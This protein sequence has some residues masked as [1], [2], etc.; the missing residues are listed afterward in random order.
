[1][2][3][4]SAN[5]H[6]R[7]GVEAGSEGRDS[8][9]GGGWGGGSIGSVLKGFGKKVARAAQSGLHQIET[10]LENLDRQLPS[11]GNMSGSGGGGYWGST[12]SG[13]D[14]TGP[15]AHSPL[16]ASS[17][18][19]G[20][21]M[22]AVPHSREEGGGGVEV[23]STEDALAVAVRVSE[24]SLHEQE[25]ALMR[26]PRAMRMKVS[27]IM[28][29]QAHLELSA[30]LLAQPAPV[31]HHQR[32]AYPAT[33]VIQT[34]EFDI[35]GYEPAAGDEVGFPGGGWRRAEAEE[36]SQSSGVQQGDPGRG[37]RAEV[38]WQA[39][40]TPGGAADHHD[41]L[42]FEEFAPQT[43]TV[44]AMSAGP[45]MPAFTAATTVHQQAGAAPSSAPPVF[46]DMLDHDAEE[47][48]FS[49]FTAATAA[50]LP[51]ETAAAQHSQ[52]ATHIDD[53]DDFFAGGAVGPSRFPAV[54]PQPQLTQPPPFSSTCP[55]PVPSSASS[56]AGSGS[57]SSPLRGP[58]PSA[59][60]AAAGPSG[61]SGD[62][63][64]YRGAANQP[65]TARPVDNF[66]LG[67]L[68]ETEAEAHSELYAEKEVHDGAMGARAGIKG[69]G[70]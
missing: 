5:M 63:F 37:M 21:S 49:D 26:L 8:G 9:G 68:D 56:M 33:G 6:C 47:A 39:A 51:V 65:S 3:Y 16:H 57:S 4:A 25:G 11:L 46:P 50:H 52:A 45:Y 69:V 70:M 38:G 15:A 42:G 23:V 14:S 17:R 62:F 1:M 35:N 12:S 32:Q 60:A 53:M 64:S 31:P 20:G 24:L 66:L 58:A 55:I 29:E 59:Q 7:A 48:G 22:V 27:E 61:G 19:H 54:A 43:A 30:G 13:P 28:N 2:S 10:A 18:G 34:A 41:L 67:E 36:V 40:P 44:W